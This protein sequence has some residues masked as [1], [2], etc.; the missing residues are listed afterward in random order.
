M[1]EAGYSA[2][3]I[4][5][6][7]GTSRSAVI[8][9]C[10]RLGL[11][12]QNLIRRPHPRTRRCLISS[13]GTYQAIKRPPTKPRTSATVRKLIQTAV[14]TSRVVYRE[15]PPYRPRF[16]PT[17]VPTDPHQVRLYDLKPHHCRYVT[18]TPD[19]T[20]DRIALYC[21]HTATFK[22]YCPGHASIMFRC[23]AIPEEA[24]A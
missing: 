17:P 22:H 21:G 7:L 6:R 16:R 10:R 15:I 20:P 3:V 2:G 19:K 11:K 9:A 23:F 5:D 4:G 1:V 8:S 14:K 18:A 24:A 12:I 13:D